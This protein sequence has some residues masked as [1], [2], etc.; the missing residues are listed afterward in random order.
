MVKGRLESS[1][2]GALCLLFTFIHLHPFR[3]AAPMP[4]AGLAV[5]CSENTLL[6]ISCFKLTVS[7]PTSLP[8]FSTVVLNKY[9]TFV[10]E[11]SMFYSY[12]F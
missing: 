5:L 7:I 12:L 9:D 3:Y 10:F 6:L 1:P 8:Y 2:A 11:I 4:V